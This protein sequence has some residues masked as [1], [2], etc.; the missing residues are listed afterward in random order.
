[1]IV[2]RWQRTASRKPSAQG[3]L[4]A[5]RAVLLPCEQARAD[6]FGGVL[7]AVEVLADP[8]ERL[9]VA[10][11]ALAVLDVR[12]DDVAAVTHAPV[13]LVAL[14]EFL[15]HELRAAAGHD[16]L[17]EAPRGLVVERLVAPQVAPF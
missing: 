8:I 15:A 17:P 2:C 16:V 11:P 5:V 12:L 14:C 9:Q 6:Q 3:F 4:L 13:P 1:V 7:H 10:Q